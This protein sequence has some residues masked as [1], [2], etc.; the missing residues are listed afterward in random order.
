[1]AFIDIHAAHKGPHHRHG[2]GQQQKIWRQHHQQQGANR[3]QR[4]QAQRPARPDARD[5]CP[6]KGHGDDRPDPQVENQQP[7]REFGDVMAWQQQRNLR[8]PGPEEEPVGQEHGRNGPAAAHGGL[9]I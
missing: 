5:H 4:E 2:R 3:Q 7:Q 8:C 9:M 1:L 6:G